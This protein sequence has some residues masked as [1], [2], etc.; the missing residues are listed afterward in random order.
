M[1]NKRVLSGMRP[2]GKLHLGHFHGVIS[3]W[4]K[5]QDQYHCMYFIADWHALT[6]H[7]D[8]RE[9]LADNTLNVLIDWLV[10]G[11]DPEKAVLF[12]QSQLPQH[13]ELHLALSMITPLGWLERVPTYKDQIDKL[14]QLDLSTYGF[15]GYPVLQAADILIYRAELVPVGADQVSHI[16]MCREIARRFNS[17]FGRDSQFDAHLEKALSSID[18]SQR[19]KIK[20]A[21]KQFN[22]KGEKHHIERAIDELKS[23]DLTEQQ[24]N[25][26]ASWMENRGLTL[27]PEPEALLMPEASKVPGLDGQKMSKSYGNSIYIR[28]DS[29]RIVKQVKQMPTD[30]ARVRKTDPGNPDICPVWDLHKIYTDKKEKSSI[31]D[32]C[33]S[34][35]MGC[36]DCKAVLYQR[37]VED[38]KT[39]NQRAQPYLED[40]SQLIAIL[41]KGNE[42][43]A[44]LASDTIN[45]VKKS[46][47]FFDERF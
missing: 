43:A 42:Q 41:K 30:P 46:I 22:E 20:R 7:Y 13:A 3:N 8:N 36:L 38:N 45:M 9:S 39:F 47:G 23:T 12:Q 34:G 11:I 1:N 21:H 24:Q 6:T 19:K 44:D 26:V 15:L 2:T 35:S 18:A 32:G 29:D 28:D 10:S 16:E 5:L 4:K 40:Q 37:L 27:L 14:K 31:N 33:R 17:I 25:I